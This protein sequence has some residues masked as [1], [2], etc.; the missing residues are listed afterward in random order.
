MLQHHKL[1][2]RLAATWRLQFPQYP[3]FLQ[4]WVNLHHADWE[5][6]LYA[7]EQTARLTALWA[8]VLQWLC[9]WCVIWLKML[10]ICP[11][12]YAQLKMFLTEEISFILMLLKEN[13]RL[14]ITVDSSSFKQIFLLIIQV[15]SSCQFQAG[16]YGGQPVKL[17]GRDAY[18][19][20]E[21]ITFKSSGQ[22]PQE[23]RAVKQFVLSVC[24]SNFTEL[25]LTKE[26]A[27]PVYDSHKQTCS[28]YQ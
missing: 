21:P 6:V 1:T 13:C 12:L 17:L 20:F 26:K 5:A 23:F 22:Q 9:A 3:Y 8:D 25:R 18:H 14:F 24:S 4:L 7:R 19:L 10:F 11:C 27:K 2:Y 15:I 28:W 16:S